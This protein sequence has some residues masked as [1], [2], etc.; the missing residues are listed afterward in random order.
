MKLDY[1]TYSRINESF[2]N[3]IFNK[4]IAYAD[5]EYDN[6]DELMFLRNAV[7]SYLASIGIDNIVFGHVEHRTS[8]YR[9]ED[10]IDLIYH[11]YDGSAVYT[12]RVI[13]G[14]YILYINVNADTREENFGSN[15][16]VCITHKN[17]MINHDLDCNINNIEVEDNIA[18]TEVGGE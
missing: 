12:I 18:N 3:N 9:N 16:F 5:S 7:E 2:K 6:T 8:G 15:K 11:V 1:V 4:V 14:L 10:T 13:E 17:Y